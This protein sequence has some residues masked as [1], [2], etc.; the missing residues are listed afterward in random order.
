L[1]TIAGLHFWVI[2]AMAILAALI[3]VFY[4]VISRA[5]GSGIRSEGRTLLDEPQTKEEP[6]ADWNFYGKP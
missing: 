1:E 5:G 6:K 3:G 2:P 4:L